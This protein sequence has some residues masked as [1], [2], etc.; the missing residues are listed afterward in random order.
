MEKFRAIIHK[1][2]HIPGKRT[3]KTHMWRDFGRII[4]VRRVKKIMN[5]MHLV[6][7][8]PKKDAYF[9]Q[10]THFHECACT[11]NYVN[12]DF[13]IGPR[14]VILTDI[15]YLYYGLNR[16]V[17]YLCVFKDAF[18]GE[19]LG[20]AVSRKMDVALV[21][22]AY[23]MM[24]EKHGKEIKTDKVKSYIHSDQGAQY[25]SADFKTLL[26][27]DEFIQSNS[28]RGN[29]QDNAPCESFFS[30]MKNETL[31]IIS[32][33][34]NFDT[35]KELIDG[36]M[37]SYNNVRY[38]LPLAGLTPHEFYLYVTTGIYPLDNYFGVKA[39]KL[40]T[41]EEIVDAKLRKAEE[42]SR[43]RK[44]AHNK[45]RL[46]AS[47]ISEPERIMVRDQGILTK[48]IYKW[49]KLQLTASNQLRF[50]KDLYDRNC[51]ALVYYSSLSKE[52]QEQFKDPLKWR[53]TPEMSYVMDMA[54]LF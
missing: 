39:D 10:A 32:R 27:D 1:L 33:C 25:L 13:K 5:I 20:F 36:Y 23:D 48:E 24:M 7:T 21:K 15:T 26:S 43:K 28:F 31:D 3:F 45:R 17:C 44:E 29:S 2:G 46:E 52:E 41:I 42:R 49:D 14:R 30:R 19:I 8:L 37:E 4:S 12:Q 16:I 35:V 11:F 6:P 22:E 54:D 50:L 53:D 40:Y 38:Q 9:G 51:K 34:K 47:K 18:T